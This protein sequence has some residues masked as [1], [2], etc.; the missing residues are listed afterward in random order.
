MTKSIP[1]PFAGR[2]ISYFVNTLFVRPRSDM[3]AAFASTKKFS[4]NKSMHCEN[5]YLNYNCCLG[6]VG[7]S[8]NS[9]S[10]IKSSYSKNTLFH[11]FYN[12]Q[13]ISTPLGNMLLCLQELGGSWCLMQ[14]TF[15]L[16][17]RSPIQKLAK[18]RHSVQSW[19]P[20]R[21]G[22]HCLTASCIQIPS[23]HRVKT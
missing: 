10:L 1:E 7:N 6:M 16:C 4:R 11:S 12:K 13:K 3:Y 18:A 14:K 22:R 19:K 5:W 20:A 21:A 15:P 23:S 8:R 9:L 17:S 2:R